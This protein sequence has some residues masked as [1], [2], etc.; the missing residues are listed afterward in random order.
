MRHFLWM[1]FFQGFW[2][3]ESPLRINPK[4]LVAW[5]G[6]CVL[7]PCQI[8]ERMHSKKILATS[9]V[10]YFQPI[11][12]MT[13]FDYVGTVLYNNSRIPNEHANLPGLDFQGRVRFVG[14]LTK[15]NCSLMI[16]QLQKKD[17]G[18][19]GIKVTASVENQTSRQIL[20]DSATLKVSDLFPN[21]TL[22]I[23]K[24]QE[25]WALQVVCSVPS[26]CPEDPI[27]MN[28]KGL[29]KYYLTAETMMMDDG[30]LRRIVTIQPAARSK[31]KAITCQ[32]SN[33]DMKSSITQEL[34]MK[35][36]PND[37]Q[38]SVVNNLPIKEGDIVT[39]NC[40]VGS[41]VSGTIWFNWWKMN[42]HVANFKYSS[43]KQLT[44]PAH[45]GPVTSYKCE[46]CNIYGCTSSPLLTVDIFFAPREV[47]IWRNPGGQIDE[48]MNV[49]LHCE[50]GEANPTNLTYT[51]YK[52]GKMI[53]L[54]SPHAY[55]NL[56]NID[57][58]QSGSY[59]CEA[60]NSVGKTLSPTITLHVICFHCDENPI[61]IVPNSFVAW[62]KSCVVIPCHISQMLSSGTV[63]AIGIVWNFKPFGNNSWS[64]GKTT[65]LYNSSQNSGTITTVS[66][67]ALPSRIWFLGNLTN[68]D[69]SL[70]INPVRMLDSGMYEVKVIVSVDK[71][72][73]QFKR[74]LTATLNV[75]ELPPEPTLEILPVNIQEKKITQVRCSVPYH[76]PHKLINLTFTGLEHF[77]PQKR[78]V[79]SGVIQ[80]TLSFEPTW[81]D[82]GKM[83]SC[84]FK[85]GAEVLSQ[86]TVKLDVRYAPK[87]V[88]LV[89]L[90]DLPIKEGDTITMNCSFGSSKPNDNWYNWFKS[91]PSTIEYKYSG[92]NV[93][94]YP[95]THG[96]YNT[97]YECEVCNRVGC[98]ASP[99]IT[100]EIFSVPKGVKILQRPEG[101]IHEPALV[102][103]KCEVEIAKRMDLTFTWYKNEELLDSTDHMLVF[104]KTNP[105]HSGIYHC[106]AENNVG[107]S[108]SPAFT[109][110]VLCSLNE[111]SCSLVPSS[112]FKF[113][114]TIKQ[115]EFKLTMRCFLW[116]LFL[117]GNCC[118]CCL[119]K[120]LSVTP[121]LLNVWEGSCVVI[122]CNIEKEYNS[123]SINHASFAWYF[124]PSFDNTLNDYSGVLLYNSN[125]TA[126]EVS[127]E[128]SNR[129]KFV[130]DLGSKNCS[131]K[132]SQLRLSDKG[133]YG[134][135]LYWIAGK[136]QTQKKWLEKLEII[137]HETPS[138]LIKTVSPEMTENNKYTVA[139]SIPYHCYDEP[140]KLSIQGLEDHLV[141]PPKI[142][143]ENQTVQ[144]EQS[145]TATWKDHGKQLT[146]L[147]KTLGREIKKPFANLMVKYCP[148]D[149][150]L[151]HSNHLPIK[152]GDKVIL[153]C[154]VGSSYPSNNNYKILVSIF[155][156][157]SRS[158]GS[159]LTVVAIPE[160]ITS[161]RCE[162]CNSV[163]CTFSPTI[164]LDI[165]YGPKDVKLNRKPSG[166]VLE[167]N[168]VHLICSVRV[169]NPKQLSYT[170]YKNGQLLSLNSAENVLFI[171]NASSTDSGIYRCVS[172][173][174]ITK[175]ESPT[176]KLEVNYAPRNVHLTLDKKDVTEGMDL[177]MRCDND[178]YP[179]VATYKWY[180]KG[181]EIPM[182]N[183]K[184]LILRKI[185]VEHSGDY[186]CRAFNTVSNRESQLI[187]I[188]VSFSR[189]TV[190]KHILIGLGVVLAFI[191]LLGSLL[192]GLKK[193]KKTIRS[194][195]DSAQRPARG[196][197][198]VRKAKRE[199]PPNNNSKLNECR[200]DC[201]LDH[202][203]EEQD[204]TISYATL[205]FPHSGLHNR[206]IYSSVM[207]PNVGL[208][209]SENSVIYSIVKKPAFH[210][211]NDTKVDYENVVKKEEE[212][213]YSSLENLAPRF[214]PTNVDL[215]TDSE[216]EDSIQ[217][218]AL[219][220]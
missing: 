188:S 207:Q 10:W 137:V 133:I 215:E 30:V 15:G 29:E 184:F 39:L 5:T 75:A 196:S 52:D 155:D 203:N 197:F 220:H 88:Q 172:K 117:P 139:C 37:V 141:L 209:S 177:Y 1:L 121:Q 112:S 183:S 80:T 95:A 178:A 3:Y 169:A 2:C 164:T 171:Q 154:S 122:S 71:Y 32:L 199:V 96:P 91:D 24:C 132:I 19:Y 206:T 201:P 74:F 129:V 151:F 36:C 109:L 217:Y 76:C 123:R 83:L 160:P 47:N 82:N 148:K 51:W 144:T 72:P 153:N 103:L 213:H 146:C 195:I 38:V 21:P 11:L 93:M 193:W 187:T 166:L 113:L 110:H 127:F 94:T 198:F 162:A 35:N 26:H 157:T 179:S 107:R 18:T 138:E 85:S 212:L 100:L 27:T 53:L 170:W 115:E 20:Y 25:R 211:K 70:L 43:L 210:P 97:S 31:K 218:A 90:N 130:G 54:D 143:T 78:T 102:Y 205:Q 56:T 126:T 69:C 79:G 214:H 14:D 101:S 46:A 165:L 67:D 22:E 124:Q 84:L 149:V 33:K 131:L 41:S 63:N 62:E 174:N 159:T 161:Y 145:F 68:R 208:D 156:D 116:M 105:S 60:S 202:Q 200:R 59:W 134:I 40:S 17:H 120:P 50:V 7:I 106:E 190:M 119:G 8:E 42:L 65:L 87:D 73:W 45:F 66:D 191:M 216:S 4:S 189:A 81:D 125:Q 16:T 55:L 77:P 104:V 176:I 182:E 9:V 108:R 194:D 89:I 128:F 44:F 140:I 180:W 34:E 61:S 142:T 64:K 23:L 6:S 219:K 135:R 118:K 86:S 150:Q 168:P 111:E 98:T 204:G 167:G 181:E 175:A 57:P 173:N 114:A 186:L 28:F 13:L 12:N 58:A 185:K 48:G 99:V 192:Y 49:V 163:G 136:L 147:L 92:P 152:E 158:Q